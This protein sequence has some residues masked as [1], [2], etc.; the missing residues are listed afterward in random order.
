M[1]PQFGYAA[2]AADERALEDIY[3][4]LGLLPASCFHA[5]FLLPC[6]IRRLPA[7]HIQAAMSACPHCHAATAAL[8]QL[9]VAMHIVAMQ[10][11][12]HQLLLRI[13]MS[14]GSVHDRMPGWPCRRT[15]ASAVWWASSRGRWC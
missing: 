14:G 7:C 15:T 13:S 5:C 6:C 8:C 9:L 4:V 12:G 11:A 1:V 10:S 3:Q 2:T